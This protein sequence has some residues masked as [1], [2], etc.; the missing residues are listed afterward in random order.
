MPEVMA[1]FADELQ[2][3]AAK[4]PF[5]HGTNGLWD[6]LKP[7]A[8]KKVLE[9]DPNAQAVYLAMAGRKKMKPI[10]DFAHQAVKRHGGTPVVAHGKVDTQKGWMPFNLTP[11]GKQNI[12]SIEDAR[13]LVESLDSTPDKKTRGEIWRKLH[14]GVGSW[15]NDDLTSTATPTHYTPALNK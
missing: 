9:S 13:E 4:I 8:V 2:K 6:V 12:G 14:Q 5:I 10:S 7:G 15:R 11:W 3:L 1:G